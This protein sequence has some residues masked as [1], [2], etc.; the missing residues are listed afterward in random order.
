VVLLRPAARTPDPGKAA[1]RIAAVEI[2]LD[3]IF[4]DQ[5]EISI[6]PLQPTL[7]FRDEPFEM[8]KK[9]AVENGAFRMTR[10]INSRHIGNEESRFA[11]RWES[12][13]NPGTVKGNGR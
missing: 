1:L 8:I 10:T 12:G 6:V 13:R 4:D 2:A 11:P 3:D 7:I 5:P 9:Y